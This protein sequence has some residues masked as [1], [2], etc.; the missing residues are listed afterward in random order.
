MKIL[1]IKFISILLLSVFLYSCETEEVQTKTASQPEFKIQDGYFKFKSFNDYRKVYERVSSFNSEQLENWNKELP[2]KSLE[3]KYKNDGINM[4][5]IDNGTE[6]FNYKLNTKRVNPT[7]ASLYNEDGV[8]VINDTIYKIKDTYL[9]LITNGDF[10]LLNNINNNINVLNNKNIQM[11]EHTI[12][13][14]PSENIN[15]E[16]LQKTISDRTLVFYV[17]ETRREFV[18]FEA[19]ISGGYLRFEMTGQYQ[20]KLLFWLPNAADE[21]VY[22]RIQVNGILGGVNINTTRPY[23]YNTQNVY[24]EFLIGSPP[25]VN[26]DLDVTYDYKKTNNTAYITKWQGTLNSTEG[27]FTKNYKSIN[28]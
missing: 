4:Y 16:G 21:L 3:T 17:S 13:I 24:Q 25:A 12:R 27:T 7:L 5:I 22:G 9:Y 6:E 8:M 19:T 28:F 26:F 20:T 2:F 23:L 18:T 15:P 10:T 1:N 11:Q 14:E